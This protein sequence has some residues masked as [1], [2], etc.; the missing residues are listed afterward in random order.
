MG[1]RL[2]GNDRYDFDLHDNRL[3]HNPFAKPKSLMIALVWL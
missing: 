3:N 1:S 2:R